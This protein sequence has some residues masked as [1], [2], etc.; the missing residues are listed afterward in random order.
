MRRL[1]AYLPVLL[2]LCAL[3]A[4]ALAQDLASFEK[5]V[6]VKK[7]PNGLTVLLLQR[8]QA[9]VFSFFTVVDAGD[10]QDPTG[11]TGLAHMM[12]HMAFKGTMNIGTTNITSETE[13]LAKVEVAYANYDRENNHRVNRDEKKIAELKTAWEEARKEAD[14]YV[15]KNEF[16]EII[17][18]NGGV[19]LNA[20]TGE[21][22][23]Q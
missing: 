17:E 23:T 2:V 1:K 15:I 13:A 21:D 10:A 8:P 4:A 14:Q 6:H 19:G 11:K 18:R 12:E 3:Q 7:L 16:G 22:S 5:R 9:P 20:S